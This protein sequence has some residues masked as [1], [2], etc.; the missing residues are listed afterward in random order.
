M[1]LN[2]NSEF[3]C[4][5]KCDFH[6]FIRCSNSSRRGSLDAAFSDSELSEKYLK[7]VFTPL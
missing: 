3:L 6:V 1:W 2:E 5:I 4:E 7:W